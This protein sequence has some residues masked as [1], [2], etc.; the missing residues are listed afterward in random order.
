MSPVRTAMLLA[1]G[2]GE[3]MRPLTDSRPKPLAELAGKPLI[4]YHIERLAAAGVE[5]VVINVAWLGSQIRATLGDGAK[6]GLQLLYSDEGPVAL[7]TGGGIVQALPLLGDD[8][9]WVI[10]ADIWTDFSFSSADTRLAPTDLAHLLMVANPD[11][12]PKGDFHLQGG[13][14]SQTNGARLTY[15]NLALFRRE[16]FV[17]CQPGRYSMVPLLRAA[18][19][20]GRVSGELFTGTWHNIGTVAQLQSLDAY[21]RADKH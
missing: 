7:E 4:Q 8:P 13:R 15:G 21:L 6:F 16:L 10:S 9:F 12:H 14:I 18:I 20:Q 19:D 2:R 17:G 1:A 3:R 5:R 11:F